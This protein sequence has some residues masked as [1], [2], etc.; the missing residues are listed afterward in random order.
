MTTA[1]VLSGGGSL[2]AVQVGMLQAL[3]ERRVVPDLLVGTSAGA[4]NAAYVAGHGTGRQ[5][6]EELAASWAGLRRRDIFPIEP[7]R[8]VL[9]LAGSR[10]SLCSDQGLRR[11]IAS[12]LSFSRLEDSAIG[13]HVVATNLLT[14]EEVL[15]SS[16]DAV[17][18]LLASSSI[19]GVLPAVQRDGLTLADGGLADNTA[20]SQAVALGADCIYVLPTGL[21]CARTEPP[22]SALAAAVQALSLLTHQRLISDV[23]HFAGRVNLNVLPPLCPLAIP[24][25]DF[26]HA[27]ELI[28]PARQSTGRWL[29]SG[30]PSRPHPERFLSLHDHN[31]YAG[32]R[33]ISRVHEPRAALQGESP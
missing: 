19:P 32:V 23:A 13:V 15:L 16:G 11:L 20:I 24:P 9:A 29:D 28:D 1:F 31:R 27:H 26:G 2:G 6:L 10:S 4:I 25:T 12:H 21:A 7:L 14:G 33:Q 17:S 8:H 18:A 30:G 22:A 5:A 3:T